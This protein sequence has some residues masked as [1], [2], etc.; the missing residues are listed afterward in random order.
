MK[1]FSTLPPSLCYQLLSS[2]PLKLLLSWCSCRWQSCLNV[3][4]AQCVSFK[5]SD[6]IVLLD[7]PVF[8]RER[9]GGSYGPAAYVFAQTL[10]SIPGILLIAVVAST[11]VRCYCYLIFFFFPP[12]S[13][14]AKV[15]WMCRL[16]PQFVRFVWF[17]LNL[18]LS[19]FVAEGLIHVISA[20]VPFFIIGLVAAA[21]IYGTTS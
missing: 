13:L 1:V 20:L 2:F 4:I 11:I 6:F 17:T 18:F 21:G 14:T 15:Y 12:P 10:V 9:A 19:L 5:V 8:V 3:R 16:N 7:K